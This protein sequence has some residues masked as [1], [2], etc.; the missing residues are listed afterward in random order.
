MKITYDERSRGLLISFGDPS[1][2][3]VS[4]EVA[5]GVVV[6]F[7]ENGKALAVEIEDVAA[8]GDI[9]VETTFQAFDNSKRR[10]S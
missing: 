1:H 10:S 8:L 3:R 5:E 9:S 7:D 6:D 4:K 2:Y